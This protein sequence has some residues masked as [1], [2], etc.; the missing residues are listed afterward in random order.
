MGRQ[1]HRLEQNRMVEGTMEAIEAETNK[2]RDEGMTLRER[3]AQSLDAAH[4]LS[5]VSP[6]PPP[7]PFRRA[8]A[9]MSLARGP[10]SVRSHVRMRACGGKGCV[11]VDGVEVTSGG[12]RRQRRWRSWRT[13]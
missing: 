8:S 2:D 5:A 7:L 13:R 9:N 11:G 1:V 4:Q 12:H 6:P 3:A 10:S